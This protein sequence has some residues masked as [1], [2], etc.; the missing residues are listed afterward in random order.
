M[1]K[2]VMSAFDEVYIKPRRFGYET[3]S[4]FRIKDIKET[5]N[6]GKILIYV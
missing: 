6:V 2:K 4:C 1:E 3:Q 5:V